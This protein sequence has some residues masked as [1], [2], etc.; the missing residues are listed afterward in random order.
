M[1]DLDWRTLLLQI[2][3]FVALLVILTQLVFKPL[4][5]KLAERGQTISDALQAAQDQEAEAARLRSYWEERRAQA[6]AHAQ[7]IV[8]AAQQ[9]AQ[10]RAEQII[11]DARLELDR[12]TAEMRVDL[13]HERDEIVSRQYEDILESIMILSGNV[14]RSVTT[15]RTHDDLVSNFIAGLL[16]TPPDQVQEYRA[17]MAGR[18]PAAFVTTPVPLTADQIKTIADAFSSVMDRRIEIRDSIDQALI[19]GIQVRIA[20]RLME[21]SIRQQ[22]V[23]IRDSV[24]AE[25]VA[26]SQVQA[27]A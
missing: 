1:L 19:A 4:R 27:D 17:A 22:L 23:N 12:I 8:H 11:S 6:E 13:A 9:N 3:N 2:L 5:R 21:S 15:R 7:E 10:V 25:F 18:V 16:R 26:Q 24:R 14:I 20:D